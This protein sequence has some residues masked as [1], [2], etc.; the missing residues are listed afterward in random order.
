MRPFAEGVAAVV[1]DVLAGLD[2]MVAADVEKLHATEAVPPPLPKNRKA[3]LDPEYVKAFGKSKAKKI[4]AGEL[5][6]ED[7]RTYDMS[8]L[9]AMFS[10]VWFEWCFSVI[11]NACAGGYNPNQSG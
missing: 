3:P 2:P 5:V 6:V 10:T 7:G 9:K 1:D 8:L 4:A 11:L